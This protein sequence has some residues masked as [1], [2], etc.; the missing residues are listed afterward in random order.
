MQQAESIFCK[1]LS[2]G[3]RFSGAPNDY[4]MT[5]RRAAALR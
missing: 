1:K 2:C 5:G 3:C 4:L